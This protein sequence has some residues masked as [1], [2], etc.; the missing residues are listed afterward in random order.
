M[1][2]THAGLAGRCTTRCLMIV[3]DLFDHGLGALKV[4][5]RSLNENS[6]HVVIFHRLKGNLNLCTALGLQM[7]DCLT[8]LANDQADNIVGH[9]HNVCLS[10]WRSIWCHHCI[11]HLMI[12]Q[13]SLLVQVIDAV[14]LLIFTA[15]VPLRI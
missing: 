1:P 13:A 8:I 14:A 15:R 11:V 5:I 6:A 12:V 4:D 7:P 2:A 10:G 3:D 9:W